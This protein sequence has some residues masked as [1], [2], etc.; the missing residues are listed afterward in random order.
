MSSN[1][2]KIPVK[3]FVSY[4]HAD[5][6]DRVQGSKLTDLR[7]RLE[8][9]FRLSVAYQFNEWD[10]F[11]I[12]PGENWREIIARKL[13]DCDCG[14]IM[15]SEN[16]LL[17]EFISTVE[18]PA[19]LTGGKA[20]IPVCFGNFDFKHSQGLTESQIWRL[21]RIGEKPRSFAQC[22]NDGLKDEFAT[23]LFNAVE[24]VI[25]KHL[26]KDDSESSTVP[27]NHTTTEIAPPPVNQRPTKSPA[28]MVNHEIRETAIPGKI[29]PIL[30]RK[31]FAN[32]YDAIKQILEQ[33]A[34]FRKLLVR[35]FK[36]PEAMTYDEI[37]L[38]LMVHFN[39]E[40]LEVLTEFGKIYEDYDHK[41]LLE[42]LASSAIYLAMDV[43]FV[44]RLATTEKPET[45]Q[46]PIAADQGIWSMLICWTHY[47]L[48]IPLKGHDLARILD[49]PLMPPQ[50]RYEEIRQALILKY[51]I[52]P[53]REDVDATLKAKLEADRNFREPKFH[54]VS[55]DDKDLIDQI[56][57][58]D[59]P[60]KDLLLLIKVKDF[61]INPKSRDNYDQRFEEH[62]ARLLGLIERQT[63]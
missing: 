22:P 7:I 56:K 55:E 29:D 62:Y 46:I 47:R 14:L 36:V 51:K 12:L 26:Q 13:E 23:R 1:Q 15:V 50:M 60:L 31:V 49:S 57:A 18:L 17:S 35:S 42:K 41:P 61:T 28:P 63:P 43:D 27:V 4:A 44:R 5:F 59:S 9:K 37:T 3:V 6:E 54:P 45:L 11:R 58:P 8:K 38:H 32:Q 48:R 24:E 21:R 33:N 16:L 19:L 20:C 40:F 10:D 25:A 30:L 52:N 39:G 53:N 2:Q 34:D